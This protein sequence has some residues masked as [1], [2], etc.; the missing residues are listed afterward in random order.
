MSA[1]ATATEG[2]ET[3]AGDC[4]NR[5]G[6]WGNASCPELAIHAHCRNCPI[7][8][9][10][11]MR[12]LGGALPGGYLEEWSARI[13]QEIP[14]AAQATGSVVIFRVAAEWFALQT[15]MFEE[16]AATRPIHALPHR[17]S[18]GI[19]GLAN[20]RGELVPCIALRHLLGLA[21]AAAEAAGEQAAPRLLVV[22]QGVERAVFPVEEVHGIHRFELRELQ[23]PPATLAGPA[24]GFATGVLRWRERSVGVLDGARLFASINRSLAL[25]TAT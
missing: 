23:A 2:K 11:A 1:G 7:Y 19:L 10:A 24:Q 4:W 6:A 12:H 21:A 17:R 3:S 13:A 22:R 16:V 25:A 5:I 14:P 20:I 18:G 9:S 15:A 8:A